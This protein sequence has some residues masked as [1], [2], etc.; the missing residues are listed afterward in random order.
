MMK[1]QFRKMK[2]IN[3]SVYQGPNSSRSKK[4][5]RRSVIVLFQV[6]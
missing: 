5:F 6:Q 2:E 1:T 3:P 4:E